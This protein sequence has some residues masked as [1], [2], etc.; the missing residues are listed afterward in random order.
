MPRDCYAFLPRLFNDISSTEWVVVS[1]MRREVYCLCRF[2]KDVE[3]GGCVSEGYSL[4]HLPRFCKTVK[5]LGEENRYPG[6]DS[7][8]IPMPSES[9]V[10]SCCY[11]RLFVST[12]GLK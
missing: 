3:S 7:N 2:C 8:H 9:S 1:G 10:E 12:S 11:V 4:I 6:Q 5:S